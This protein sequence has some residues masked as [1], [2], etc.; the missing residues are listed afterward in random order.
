MKRLPLMLVRCL[1]VAALCSL[2]GACNGYIS[3]GSPIGSGQ[4]VLNENNIRIIM[5]TLKCPVIVDAGMGSPADAVQA[6]E[7]GLDGVLLNTA[8]AKAVNPVRMAHAFG[9]GIRAGRLAYE[10]GVMAKQDMA[11]ASTPVAGYPILL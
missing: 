6:M 7:L 2:L 3:L 4:G 9:L 11:V 5:E 1:P 8:V 10:A